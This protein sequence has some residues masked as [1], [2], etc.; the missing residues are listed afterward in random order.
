MPMT[1]V[2]DDG[3]TRRRSWVGLQTQRDFGRCEGTRDESQEA[4]LNPDVRAVG[5][6]PPLEDAV[7]STLREAV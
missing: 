3:E 5:G 1:D 2:A 4:A 7:V 6:G